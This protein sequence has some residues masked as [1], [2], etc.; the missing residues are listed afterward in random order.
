ML[1]PPLH[2]K[3]FFFG[4]APM[5]SF[6]H[7]EIAPKFTRRKLR[8]LRRIY[9]HDLRRVAGRR[10]RRWKRPR[11]GPGDWRYLHGRVH[12]ART[13]VTFLQWLLQPPHFFDRRGHVE[14]SLYRWSQRFSDPAYKRVAST[15]LEG[16]EG[17]RLW[18]STVWLGIDHGCGD[19]PRPLIYESMAF[20]DA[21]TGSVIACDRYATLDEARAG[22][23]A[24]VERYRA[25]GGPF[26]T[27]PND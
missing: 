17:T 6:R 22:H 12:R 5:Q 21:N 3:G 7:I 4:S 20:V 26:R 9:N 13:E 25:D 8:Q 24:M 23:A 11:R 27:E 10:P 19:T 18:I 1:N 14:R 2:V 16:A 15:T